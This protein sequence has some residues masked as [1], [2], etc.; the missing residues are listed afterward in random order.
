[1]RPGPRRTV[2]AV[3]PPLLTPVQGKGSPTCTQSM[4]QH[5]ASANQLRPSDATSKHRKRLVTSHGTLSPALAALPVVYEMGPSGEMGEPRTHKA[6]APNQQQAVR[7]GEMKPHPSA[8]LF[9]G[10]QSLGR[11]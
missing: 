9:L 2:Q 1:M 7:E 3:L 6:Y 5:A 8:T 10:I 4:S 11:E